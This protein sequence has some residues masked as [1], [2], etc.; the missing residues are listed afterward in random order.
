LWV[1]HRKRCLSNKMRWFQKH[2]GV[3]V[4]RLSVCVH[5]ECGL[6]LTT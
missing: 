5:P 4:I 3:I 1:K 2:D 6:M